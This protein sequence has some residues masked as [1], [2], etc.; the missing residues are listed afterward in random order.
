MMPRSRSS[1][2]EVVARPPAGGTARRRKRSLW[3]RLW[4][5]FRWPLLALG[6]ILAAA[7]IDVALR[8]V[9]AV[10]ALQ[11]GRTEVTQ[12][13]S[14]LTGDL[15]HLDQARVAQA[16]SLLADAELDFGSRSAVLADGWIGGVVAHLPWVGSQVDAA[17][18]L[19]T[20]GEDGTV[21]GTNVV[22]LVEQ[23]V[24]NGSSTQV[25]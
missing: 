6:V 1:P 21:A 5:R 15:A 25:P 7:V 22:G 17:R 11:H 8:Y 13:Q 20:A 3:R 10:Q 23:L 2:T 18:L 12:A 24:P 19:R 16:R 14:V 4:L 9:P